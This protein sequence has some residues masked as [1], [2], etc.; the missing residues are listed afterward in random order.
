MEAFLTSL[1]LVAIAEIGDKTQLLAILL[2]FRFRRPLP[3]IAGIFVATVVNH[4]LAAA[5]G[6]VAADL[7]SGRGFQIALGV[8]FIAMGLWTLV[9][10]KLDESETKLPR[11]GPFL[12]TAIAFLL[13][14][15]WS[16]TSICP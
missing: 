6:S 16:V 11:F 12:A 13:A 9:P 2:A 5:V 4:A 15:P 8:S 1:G 3:I 14:S 10:D 7:I